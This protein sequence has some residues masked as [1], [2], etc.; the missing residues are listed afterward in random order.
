MPLLSRSIVDLHLQPARTMPELVRLFR[1]RQRADNPGGIDRAESLH[2]DATERDMERNVDF[3][4][5]KHDYSG[6]QH[7]HTLKNTALCDESQF[8]HFAGYTHR[9]AIADKTMVMDELPSF[10]S[11]DQFMLWLTK[12]KGY[13]GYQPDGVFLAQPYKAARNHPLDGLEKLVN[14]AIASIRIVCE[15]AIGGVKRLRILKEQLRYNNTDF[16][17]QIFFIGCGLHNFRVTRRKKTY[18][19]GALR[20]RARLNLDF[21]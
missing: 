6:K 13:Q 10:Q 4:A 21:S 12:D 1:S 8:I 3:E 2:L 19:A 7:G 20:V 18:A 14:S 5:Q 11:L 9:G 17:D 15:H 16:R